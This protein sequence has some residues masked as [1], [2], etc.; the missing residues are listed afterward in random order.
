MPRF[1]LDQI[2]F[3]TTEVCNQCC[4][5]CY[6]HWRDGRSPLPAPDPVQ[7][8]RTLRKLLK[9]VSVGTLSFS[10]GEPLLLGNIAD[11]VLS[12]RFKGSRVNVLTN[13]TLLTDDILT[14]FMHLGVG[15]VQVP[16]LSADAAVHEYLTALPGSW[17]KAVK[18]LR[19]VGEARIGA[20]VLVLTR[21]NA[22]GCGRTLELIRD[23]GIRTVMVN[24]FNIGGMGLRNS[25]ELIP[26]RALLSRTFA[27]IEAFA[28]AHPDMHFVSGVCTPLCYLDT[29]PFP[30]IRF[31]RCSP[32]LAQRPVTVHYRGD[33]RFCNH[34]P[35]VLGNLHE[36]S[37]ADILAD[38]GLN[39]WYAAV[40]D[41]CNGCS[42]LER[43]GCG[44][45]AASEQ[46]FGTFAYADPILGG[47]WHTASGWCN[48][49]ERV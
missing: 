21:V 13:G 46:V 26:D 40:P 22:D 2:V 7:A 27:L 6:N 37:L 32:D 15:T 49:P 36:R 24:R 44:C 34:S 17:E 25:G 8:R 39:A 18:A 16:L 33:V 14:D 43:C 20:A 38:P 35:F 10:G 11:L 42:L 5:F 45:R 1:H 3:E 29:A 31:S 41:G 23:C 12:A 19:R 30:H 47:G 48:R 4:R 28:A 9:E